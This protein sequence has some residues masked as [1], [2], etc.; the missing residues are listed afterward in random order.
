MADLAAG[1][2]THTV[3]RFNPRSSVRIGDTFEIA[4]DTHRL[5]FFDLDTSDKIGYHPYS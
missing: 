5:H 4:V 1:D 2:G 3:A